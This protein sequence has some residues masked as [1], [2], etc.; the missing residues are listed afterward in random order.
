[1]L[2]LRNIIKDYKTGDSVVRALDGISLRFRESEF[3]SILGPSGCGKTTLLN[4]V[5]GLD[6]YTSGDLII[7][8]VSTKRYKDADWD[9]YRNHSIGFVFQSYNLI[10]HQTVLANVELALTLSGISKKERRA[11]AKQALEDVGLGNQL[12]KR[13][14][15]LSGGQMQRVAIARALVND[16]DILLADEPT[17]ALDTKT[18]VQI[19]DILRSISHKKLIIM[20]THNPDLAKEYSSRIISVVDGHV[21]DDSN[22]YTLEEELA[23]NP[24]PVTEEAKETRA[25]KKAKKKSMSFFT[26]LSLSL[27]NLLTKKGRTFMTSFAGSIGIIGIAL[28]LAVS[29]GVNNY[30]NAVQRDTLSTYPLTINRETQDYSALLGAMTQVR[31]DASGEVDDNKIYVDD[32]MGTMMS[33]MTS[34]VQ[35]NLEAF[36]KYID[37]HYDEK[38]KPYVSD[39]QYA[40]DYKLQVYTGDGKTQ[41]S[42]TTMFDNMGEAF[43]GV[44][45]LME[46]GGG[47]SIMSEMINNQELLDEQYELVGEDSRWPENANEVVLVVSRN[48]RISKMT[49]YMLGVLSQEGLDQV[50][51]DLL[52]GNYDTTPMEPYNLSDFLG[53]EFMMLNTSDFFAKDPH[54]TY[55]LE[56]DTEYPVWYDLRNRF[57]TDEERSEFVTENGTKLVISGIVRPREGVSA[58]SIS[59]PIGYTK[60]L[61]DVILQKN[62]ASEVLNQQKATPE[63]NVLTG[64]KFERTVYTRENID[65]LI[66]KVD[67]ATMEQLYA[68]MTQEILNNPE[69]QAQLKIEN[70]EAFLGFFM[71]MP[72]DVQL[73]LI[74]SMLQVAK[75]LDPTGENLKGILD[76]LTVMLQQNGTTDIKVTADNF[77]FLMPQLSTEQVLA[78]LNGIPAGEQEFGGMTITIPAIPGLIDACGEQAM[79]AIYANMSEGILDL[80]INDEIFTMLMQGDFINDE[81]FKQMEEMLYNLAPQTDATYAS[82]LSALGDAV[83]SKPSSIYFYAKDFESK[84]MV[85]AFITEYNESVEEIDQL[86]YTDIVKT[87]MSSVTTIVNAISYVLIAFV[88]IS[89]VVSSIMIGIITYISVLERTKEIGILR[90]IG[91]SKKD[92]SRVFNAETLIVGFVAGLIGILVSLG[93]IVVINIILFHFTGIANLQA[94]LPPVAAIILVGISMFLTFIAG[95]FPSGFAAKRNP[96]EALRSE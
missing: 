64:L 54:K 84:D 25:P 30:I 65:E 80:T 12:D 63:H 44:D 29:T 9:T 46:M 89:L 50:I 76:T 57:L 15:Q 67:D 13:P 17:G 48:N 32:S 56:D 92:I 2:E 60:A 90:S 7:N 28:I 47:F 81:Q 23:N 42:P 19:M 88:A 38:L 91:A 36:K 37:E 11:R 86:K 10:P 1:M 24:A 94:F 66:S 58:T 87:L 39:I 3:V 96:V 4:I 59:T 95:L 33:A 62:A 55:T 35:N 40:Y 77:L 70:K 53:M 93:L 75:Q 61:S 43:S 41:I 73:E 16:P 26:A 6:Q 51:K 83:A 34:T 31:E 22:P 52:E 72:D 74:G 49:L 82:T 71:L 5:G 8:G 68:W 21:V 14:N 79:S 20:V 69:T 85:E 18:S 45:Q 27:N 78:F